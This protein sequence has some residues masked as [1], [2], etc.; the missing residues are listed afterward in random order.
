MRRVVEEPRKEAKFRPSDMSGGCF[1]G[2][3]GTPWYALLYGHRNEDDAREMLEPMMAKAGLLPGNRVLDL[4]CGRGR[5]AAVLVRKGLEVTGIDISPESIKEAR[6]A[7]P[8]A[9]FDVFDIREPYATAA[10]DAVICL[11]TS[12]GYTDDREDDARAV[13]AAAQALKHN[14]LFILDLMNGRHVSANLVREEVK[15]VEG[16]RFEINRMMEGTDVLKQIRV[17][18]PGGEDVYEE[19]VHA[20]DL[21]EVESMVARAGLR[22]E[23]VTDGSC[24]LPFDPERSER[25]VTWAR[26]Q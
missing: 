4:A 25:M 11:F 17:T 6:E 10:Y 9:H 14:G 18:H 15:E 13:Q 3:F 8:T 16:V 12:L 20:W 1:N 2:W 23:E 26:K 5:H 7:A 21:P 22:V 19:R 24:Q